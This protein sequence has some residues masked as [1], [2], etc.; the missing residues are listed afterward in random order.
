MKFTFDQKIISYK[1]LKGK[2]PNLTDETLDEFLNAM[3][4][5]MVFI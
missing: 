1:I 4:N 5:M 3:K 2:Y